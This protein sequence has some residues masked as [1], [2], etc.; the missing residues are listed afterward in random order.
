MREGRVEEI[1]CGGP[2]NIRVDGEMRE[3]LNDIVNEICLLTLMEVNQKFQQRLSRKSTVHDQ[4]VARA[5]DG[6]PWRVKLARPLPVDRNKP[7]VIQKRIEY[8]KWFMANGIVQHCIF[9]DECG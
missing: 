2:N 5:L 1:P 7:D 4:T 8:A 6:M 9:I 3:C